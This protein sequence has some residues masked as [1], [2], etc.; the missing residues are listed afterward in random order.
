MINHLSTLPV[1]LWLKNKKLLFNGGD[2]RTAKIMIP[3]FVEFWH[4]TA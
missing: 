3:P 4:Y 2:F 1:V